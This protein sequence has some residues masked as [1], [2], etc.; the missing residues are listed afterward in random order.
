MFY[1]NGSRAQELGSQFSFFAHFSCIVSASPVTR[2]SGTCSVTKIST[3]KLWSSL[4]ALALDLY[5]SIGISSGPAAFP[6]LNF[7]KHVTVSSRV[8]G[9]TAS[10][11]GSSRLT[12]GSSGP[13]SNFFSR[14][15]AHSSSCFS[16]LIIGFPSLSFEG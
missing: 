1:K 13:F 2:S 15:S 3:S 8:G 10:S 7:F 5:C 4:Q 14:N 16:V 6:L 9:G 11:S 12:S